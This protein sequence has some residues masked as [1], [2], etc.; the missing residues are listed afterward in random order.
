MGKKDKSSPS[1]I[2]ENKGILAG[3]I[4]IAVIISL[5][6]GVFIGNTFADWYYGGNNSCTPE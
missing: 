6:V 1:S 4:I 2:L 5:A 3:I